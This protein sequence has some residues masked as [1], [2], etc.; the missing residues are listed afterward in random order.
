MFTAALLRRRMVA[1]GLI[2][3]EAAAASI[4]TTAEGKHGTVTLIDDDDDDFDDGDS[5]DDSEGGG[6]RASGR[7]A[8]SRLAARSAKRPRTRSDRA[9]RSE[10]A[11]DGGG[12][13]AGADGAPQRRRVRSPFGAHGDTGLAWFLVCSLCCLPLLAVCVTFTDSSPFCALQTHHRHP[14][15]P[16]TADSV[17]RK[18]PA[19]LSSAE[20]PRARQHEPR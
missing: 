14:R 1:L 15:V 9:D 7:E 6:D 20:S 5:T 2:T 12:G 11:G 8:T 17:T 10:S 18:N 4:A 16:R 3:P 19:A 13:G